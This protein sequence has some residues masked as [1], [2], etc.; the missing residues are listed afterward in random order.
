M[1]TRAVANNPGFIELREIQYALEVANT[2][3]NSQ[4]KVYL[5]SDVL[6]MSGLARE[7]NKGAAPRKLGWGGWLGSFF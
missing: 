2:I 5:S 7:L 3:A 4:F 1:T 6:L